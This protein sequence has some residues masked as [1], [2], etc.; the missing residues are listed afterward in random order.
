MS[1]SS[2]KSLRTNPFH[3]YRDPETGQ[4]KVIMVDA[5]ASVSRQPECTGAA[6]QTPE[7]LRHTDG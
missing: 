6:A 2:E 1:C 5:D 4:W 7:K 3:T